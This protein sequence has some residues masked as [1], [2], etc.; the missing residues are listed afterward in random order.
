MH[1]SWLYHSGDPTQ[2]D[3]TQRKLKRDNKRRVF[4]LQSARCWR[5]DYTHNTCLHLSDKYELP[6]VGKCA[7]YICLVNLNCE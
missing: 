2:S 6:N 7:K 4:A 5:N 1:A 3:V